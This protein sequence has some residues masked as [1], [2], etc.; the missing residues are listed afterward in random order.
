MYSYLIQNDLSTLQK[1][2]NIS[3]NKYYTPIA[4]IDLNKNKVTRL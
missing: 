3:N 1:S 4:Q 2:L